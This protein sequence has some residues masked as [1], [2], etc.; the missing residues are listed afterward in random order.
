MPNIFLI[1]DHR[2][3]LD[4]LMHILKDVKGY[5]I[6]CFTNPLKALEAFKTQSVDLVVTDINMKELNGLELMQKMRVKNPK[7]KLLA[8]SVRSDASLIKKLLDQ[9]VEGYLPK[10][11]S[12]VQ[13]IGTVKKIL[14][15]KK[16]YDMNYLAASNNEESQEKK[17][18]YTQDINPLITNREKEV[19][20]L[21]V[22]G[23]TTLEIA[24]KLDLSEHTI[25]SHR[26]NI[27]FKLDAKNIAELITKSV[28]MGLAK[29]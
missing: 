22:E 3:F 11:A 4:G 29:I 8:V 1:D 9:S 15:G 18:L 13:F 23:K 25:N 12:K 16:H 26:K 19:L 14:S 27:A 28:K 24:D 21:V 20:Q 7:I 5:S 6:H 17:Y 10:N 2:L